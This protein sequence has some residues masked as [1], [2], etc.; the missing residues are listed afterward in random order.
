MLDILGKGSVLGSYSI[1]N[2]SEYQFSGKAKSS[3]SLLVLDR[4]DLLNAAEKFDAVTEA[5]EEAT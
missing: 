3:L 1:I 2:E 5:I 4:E